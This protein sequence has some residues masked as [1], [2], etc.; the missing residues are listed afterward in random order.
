[1]SISFYNRIAFNFEIFNTTNSILRKFEIAIE[2]WGA[3]WYN[4]K[5]ED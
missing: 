5:K 1:L 3:V 2:I 4:N